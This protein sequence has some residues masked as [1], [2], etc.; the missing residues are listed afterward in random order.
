MFLG[1][2][3]FLPHNTKKKWKMGQV[4]HI[5]VMGFKGASSSQGLLH[6][7]AWNWEFRF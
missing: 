1:V 7:N 6:T 2:F 3:E 4:P 5:S